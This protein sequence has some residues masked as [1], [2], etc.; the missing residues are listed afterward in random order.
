LS[1]QRLEQ[2]EVACA[3]AMSE[4]YTAATGVDYALGKR[5]VI[6]TSSSIFI[7]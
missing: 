3:G 5:F 4:S 1:A 2:A 6:G 7:A